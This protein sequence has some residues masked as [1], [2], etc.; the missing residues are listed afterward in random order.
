VFWLWVV[1]GVAGVLLFWGGLGW[2]GLGD[3]VDV[4]GC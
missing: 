2:D 3:A 4:D 1:D